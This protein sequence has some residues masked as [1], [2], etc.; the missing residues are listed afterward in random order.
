MQE[1]QSIPPQSFGRSALQ[2]RGS[3]TSCAKISSCKAKRHAQTEPP[4]HE[5]GHPRRRAGD[6]P[7]AATRKADRMPRFQ[8]PLSLKPLCD[9]DRTMTHVGRMFP[10]VKYTP[11]V[12]KRSERGFPDRD[13]IGW[14]GSTNKERGPAPELQSSFPHVLDS[15]LRQDMLPQRDWP[16]K[17]Q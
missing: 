9:V 7:S 13:I 11:S 8:I 5:D 16:R 10:R 12:C 1:R 6:S 15:G 14:R 2:A 17:Q 4:I 3:S